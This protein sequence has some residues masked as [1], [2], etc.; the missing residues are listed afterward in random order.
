METLVRL[1]PICTALVIGALTACQS[2][3]RPTGPLAGV[4]D[5]LLGSPQLECMPSPIIDS[6]LNAD[7]TPFNQGPLPHRLCADSTSSPMFTVLFDATNKVLEVTR[8]FA[9]GTEPKDSIFNALDGEMTR[10]YGSPTHCARAHNSILG[11]RFWSIP[12]GFARLDRAGD[13]IVFLAL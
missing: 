9:V 7:L 4:A 6:A 8:L 5:S 13:R 12:A 2:E 10:R 1:Q 3:S 11:E